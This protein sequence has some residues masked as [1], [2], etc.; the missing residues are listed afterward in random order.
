M[1]ALTTE[2]AKAWQG[3]KESYEYL[4]HL[5]MNSDTHITRDIAAILLNSA[6]HKVTSTAVEVSRLRFLSQP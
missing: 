1:L 6:V 4:L 5:A 3:V 2:E